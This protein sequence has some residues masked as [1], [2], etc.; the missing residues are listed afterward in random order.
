MSYFL[1]LLIFGIVPLAFAYRAPGAFDQIRS[2]LLPVDS[3]VLR[4][5]QTLL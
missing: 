5:T 4:F 3:V 1:L 2:P